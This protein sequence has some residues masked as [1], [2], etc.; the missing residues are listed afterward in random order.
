MTRRAVLGGVLG[1][2]GLAACGS[3]EEPPAA[4]GV[5]RV[6]EAQGEWWLPSGE[7]PAPTVV[8]VHGGYWRP[9]FDRSL[10]D[11]VAQV[12]AEAGYVVWNVDYR[13]SD[14]PWPATLVDV[15]AAHDRISGHPRVDPA[16]TAV[17]GHS[18][19]GHLALWLASRRR[20][21]QGAA[22]SAPAAPIPRLVVAQAPV[23]ALA[24]AAQEGLGEGAAVALVDGTPTEVPDRYAVTD[25]V[26]LAPTGVRTVLLHSETD[27]TVPLSQSEA[28]V[29]ADPSAVLERVPG[30]HF[31]HLDPASEAVTALLRLLGDL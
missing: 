31:A 7:G 5:V 3:D 26:A 19:G 13:A 21:P 25:P 15:A 23:A 28:Y 10:E 27:G 2:A 12:L 24:L 4:T 8:L 11:P 17:V 18:A 1:A 30:D 6:P 16:R 22:G 29:T 20:L 14:V 9:G